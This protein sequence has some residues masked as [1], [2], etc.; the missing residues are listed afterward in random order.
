MGQQIAASPIARGEIAQRLNAAIDR[1]VSAR[2]ARLGR[3]N[4]YALPQFVETAAS[5]IVALY[6]DD[7]DDVAERREEKTRE[8]EDAY[9]RLVAAMAEAAATIPDYP[10]GMLGEESRELAIQ[11]IGRFPP[12]W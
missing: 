8:G 10:A 4:E 9:E 6:P 12:F 2:G 5:A 7:S 11:R 3:G 1:S